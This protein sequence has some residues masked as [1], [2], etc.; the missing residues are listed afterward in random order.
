MDKIEFSRRLKEAE[1]SSGLLAKSMIDIL[2]EAKQGRSLQEI[3][4]SLAVH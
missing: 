1:A 2:D 3:Y 4:K